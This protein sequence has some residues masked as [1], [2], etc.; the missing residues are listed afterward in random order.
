MPNSGVQGQKI[1]NPII[2]L[3]YGFTVKNGVA[4]YSPVKVVQPSSFQM[5][6]IR[7]IP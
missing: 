6:A 3:N 2:T 5:K 1:Y 4:T 7:T